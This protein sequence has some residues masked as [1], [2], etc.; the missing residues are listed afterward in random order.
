MNELVFGALE[1][2]LAKRSDRR[3]GLCHHHLSP[4]DFEVAKGTCGQVELR[5]DQIHCPATL[6]EFIQT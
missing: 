1:K 2:R 3:T 5:F 6:T 4:R